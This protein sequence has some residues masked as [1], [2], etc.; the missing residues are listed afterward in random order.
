MRSAVSSENGGY[1]L[2][3]LPVGPYEL[4]ASMPG[5]KLEVRR[6]INLVVGQEAVVNL[7]LEAGD[8][9]EQITLTE[10]APL[11]NTTPNST[12]GLIDEAQLKDLP[13]NGRG[14]DQLLTLNTGTVDNHSNNHS[15]TSTS[16]SVAGKRPETN[17]YLMN[18]VDYIG[19]NSNGQVITPSGSSGQ[20][21]GVEAVREYN[22]I[23]HTYGA[24]Y[25]KRAGAQVAIVSS[26]GTN[27]WH[28][29]AFEYLRNSAFDAR[30]FFDDTTGAPPFKRNQFGG[31]LGGPLKKGKA[32]LFGNYEG[33][34]ERL[35]AS[36]VA[37]VPDALARQ[38]QL[39]NVLLG[40]PKTSS[41]ASAYSFVPNLKPGMLAYANYFWPAPNGPE[42][43]DPDGL[44]TGT[45]KAYSNPRRKVREDFV[46]VRFDNRISGKD[47]FFVNFNRD[48][49][50]KAT[51]PSDPSFST[52]TTQRSYLLGLQET[53]IFSQALLNVATLGY[54][55]ARG[56]S[57]QAPAAPI[58]SNLVF[59]TGTNPGSITIGGGATS[60]VAAA[61]AQAP[62]NAGNRDTRNHVTWADD[63]RFTR[64]SHSWSAGAWVQYIQQNT[65]GA[66]QFTAG[67]INY[68]TLLA[69]LQDRPTQ[70]VAQTKLQPLY[71]RSTEAAWYVQDEMKLRP[72][73]TMRLGLREEM[74]SGWDEV[75]NHASNYLFDKSG[76]IQTDPMIGHSAFTKNNAKAL[77]QPRVG[78]AWDPTGTGKWSVRAGFGIHHDLQD[79]V[80]NRLN[81]DPPFGARLT[82]QNTPLLSIIPIP[83][84]TP[85]PPS[86]NA[87]S[88]LVPPACGIFTPGGLDPIMKT[89]ALQ[90]WS[91]TVE[92]GLTENLV[93]QVGY[94]GSE[95][96]HVVALT[97][98]NMAPPQICSDFQG[99]LSG[100]IRTADQA[101]RVPQGTRYMPS[102]PPVGTLQMRPDPYVGPTQSWLYNAT[103][104]Y[105]AGGVSLT[106]RA[107]RGL[108]FKGN[109]TYSKVLDINSAAI[110]ML[111]ANEPATV[112]NPFDMKLARGPASYN[113]THQFNA[114]YSYQL[115]FGRGRQFGGRASEAVD[116]LIS[117]WQ[118]NGSV[119]VQSGFPFTP[120]VGS[121]SSG[122]GDTQ[123]PDVPNWNPDFHG[124]LI[125]GRPDQWFDPRAFLIPTAGTFGNV[126]R[127]QLTGPKLTNFDM[128]LFKKFNIDEKRSLQ[129]RA[130]AF[131]IFNHANFGSPNAVIFSGNSFS[132]SAGVITSTST[133]SRQIQFALKLLF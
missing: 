113:L 97:N 127:G 20:L 46:L 115:P 77:W 9:A 131:N 43:L 73:L 55:R 60:V 120:L 74:T 111:A 6:G 28:G 117:G 14:V 67:T 87:Q 66:A 80:G 5:F 109:Y 92:R 54:S 132:S 79:N 103:S 91:L 52:L 125:L 101:V 65:Y 7:T 102:T 18:G 19:S 75:H 105:H 2:Q 32:F 58:P 61:I 57:V 114:N 12:S 3:F 96:Y 100:G 83:F 44:P 71:F 15:D 90:Q 119:A 85:P 122:T 99:C 126:G 1:S 35:A 68:P 29:T 121:N 72:H 78:L 104:S 16:F 11:V 34:R 42:L 41:L 51:P 89:P 129:F 81:N 53:H 25:G 33:F 88:P 31:T 64:N 23:Q 37:I 27:E 70:F 47:S 94:V 69:F 86:C 40:T 13:L 118:W 128:S 110:G 50:N 26:S 95:A 116:R 30:N 133:T 59:L 56:T 10:E 38:G 4:T 112:L 48:D 62:G 45:A 36:S 93:L 21:L 82:I 106:K 17:R 39:P 130:E 49:G 124:R 76:I 98:R 123:I 108:T 22:V 63:V 84:G 24:E 8:A 107:A